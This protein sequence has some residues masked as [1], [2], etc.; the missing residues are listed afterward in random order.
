M[1][2]YQLDGVI[3]EVFLWLEEEGVLLDLS[4][5][6]GLGEG[7]A[8]IGKARLVPDQDDASVISFLAVPR[9]IAAVSSKVPHPIRETQK[10]N[11]PSAPSEP[12]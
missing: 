6:K 4:Q 1:S 10:A 7:W 5:E 11:P 12:K 2:V 8:L 3:G 9:R